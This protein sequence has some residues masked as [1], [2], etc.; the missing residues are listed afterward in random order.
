GVPL[1]VIF[2]ISLLDGFW[3]KFLHVSPKLMTRDYGILERFMQT[4]RYHQ[5]HHAKNLRYMDTNYTSITLFWD[6]V[7]GTLQPLRDDD[8]ATYGITREVNSE[9]WWDVQT[10]EVRALWH[11]VRAAPDIKSKLLYLFMPPGWSHTGDHK[12]VSTLRKRQAAAA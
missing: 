12:M 10:G 3:G 6:W 9:S 4:P 1:E 2:F 7:M 8:P 11:D 5:V